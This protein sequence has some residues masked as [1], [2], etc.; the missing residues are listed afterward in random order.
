METSFLFLPLPGYGYL[1]FIPSSLE[2]WISTHSQF[3]S[4]TLFPSSPLYCLH[5]KLHTSTVCFAI[6]K[7][8]LRPLSLSYS[9]SCVYVGCVGV[10]LCVCVCWCRYMKYVC[11]VREEEEGSREYKPAGG[12]GLKPP[13]NGGP[14]WFQET[15]PAAGQKVS[16][17]P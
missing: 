4:L 14:V 9:L 3:F 15:G 16:R 6:C 7:F 1:I 8:F 11:C 10:F 12:R 5:I 2:L 13:Q 17:E